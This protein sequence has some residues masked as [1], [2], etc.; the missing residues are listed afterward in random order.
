[1]NSF[2]SNRMKGRASF[3]NSWGDMDFCFWRETVCLGVPGRDKIC[4][5]SSIKNAAHLSCLFIQDKNFM[6]QENTKYLISTVLFA[7]DLEFKMLQVSKQRTVWI[8]KFFSP[9]D[10][11]FIVQ[12]EIWKYQKYSHQLKLIQNNSSN[13]NTPFVQKEKIL[14]NNDD[15][16]LWLIW[17]LFLNIKKYFKMF[18]FGNIDFYI[19]N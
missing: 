5:F 6:L 9:Y 17:N 8:F 7:F 19:E 3:C 12:L 14:W 15:F 16:F 4:R 2:L 11:I 13:K 18:C 1:M 10:T